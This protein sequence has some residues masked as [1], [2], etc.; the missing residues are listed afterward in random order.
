MIELYDSRKTRIHDITVLPF[1][2]GH[3]SQSQSPGW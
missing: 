2:D 1:L 3:V